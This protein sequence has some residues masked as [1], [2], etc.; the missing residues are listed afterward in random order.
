MLRAYTVHQKRFGDRRALETAVYNKR[1][2]K[3]E[4]EISENTHNYDVWFDYARLLEEEAAAFGAA[5]PDVQQAAQA[6]AK[7]PKV[8]SAAAERQ[9]AFE[10]VRE[11]YERAIA[12]VPP[13]K[14]K[15]YWRRYIYLWIYYAVFEELVAADIE[16]ARQVFETCLK[17]L[18]LE[19][20]L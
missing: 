3:Y 17:V 18:L 15:R 19:S 5:E 10:A 8:D 9:Q 6:A 4:S 2:A 7:Q 11:V 1:K 12:Q 20:L 16:R 14:E 13:I